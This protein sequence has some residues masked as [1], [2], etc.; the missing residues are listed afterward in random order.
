[1]DAATDF[2]A[3]DLYGSHALARLAMSALVL[4][5]AGGVIAGV[6]SVAAPVIAPLA[7]V[8]EF[9]P[10]FSG[11]NC[12]LVVIICGAYR[13]ADSIWSRLRKIDPIPDGHFMELA[14]QC[15]VVCNPDPIP[16]PVL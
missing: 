4:S 15:P 2:I 9:V 11:R 3:G 10:G 1:M 8:A 6:L 7:R 13:L 12:Y 14:F 5:M 16:R